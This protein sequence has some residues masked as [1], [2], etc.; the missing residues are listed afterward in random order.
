RQDTC[1]VGSHLAFCQAQPC[2]DTIAWGSAPRND[3]RTA[4]TCGDWMRSRETLRVDLN[5]GLT[6]EEIE[7]HQ[8]AIV[9]LHLDDLADEAIE[10]AAADCHLLPDLESGLR[11]ANAAVHLPY[12]Q[13]FHK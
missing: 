2:P 13:A 9:L 8:N 6:L 3:E 11:F 10:R 4:G 12:L 1:R 7:K 5:A